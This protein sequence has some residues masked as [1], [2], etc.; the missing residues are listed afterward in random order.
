M[1][2]SIEDAQMVVNT[3]YSLTYSGKESSPRLGNIILQAGLDFFMR[4][5]YPLVQVTKFHDHKR[6]VCIPGAVHSCIVPAGSNNA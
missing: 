5:K 4:T 1:K 3:I 2:K 6:N